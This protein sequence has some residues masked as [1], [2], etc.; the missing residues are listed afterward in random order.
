[1][2]TYDVTFT[3]KIEATNYEDA[4]ELVIELLESDP[5]IESWT[6]AQPEVT[7]TT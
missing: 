7:E 1:M 4:E 3:A 5:S 2:N 6:V